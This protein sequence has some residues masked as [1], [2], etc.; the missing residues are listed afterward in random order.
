M[1]LFEGITTMQCFMKKFQVLLCTRA[2]IYF[3]TKAPHTYGAVHNKFTKK[4]KFS[5]AEYMEQT[6]PNANEP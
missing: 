2:E 4:I 5:I 1:T 3:K 6:S